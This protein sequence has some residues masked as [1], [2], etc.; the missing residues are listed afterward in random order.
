[1]NLLSK[2]LS[3]LNDDQSFLL[4]PDVTVSQH[5]RQEHAFYKIAV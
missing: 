5:E 2:L 4:H 1:M 3:Q